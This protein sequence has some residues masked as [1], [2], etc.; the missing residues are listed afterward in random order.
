MSVRVLV[1]GASGFVGAHLMRQL[2]QQGLEAVGM[3]RM[4]SQS[5]GTR[6][7]V[8]DLADAASLTGALRHVQ[9]THVFHLAGVLADAPGGYAAQYQT[10]VLGTIRLFEAIVA[11]GISPWILVA[12][13]AA[14]YGATRPEDNPLREDRPLRPVTHY[15]ASKAAQE[16]AAI[17]YAF[18]HR[19][20]V[21][22]ARTFNL[23]GPGQPGGLLACDLA[24]QIVEA[25][26]RGTPA[27][28]RVGNLSPRRDYVDVRDAVRAYVRLAEIGGAE[29]VYNV[30]T[31]RSISVQECLE[32]LAALTQAPLTIEQ[33]P[34]LMRTVDIA[35]QAGCPDRLQRATGWSAEIPLKTSLSDLLHDWRARVGQGVAAS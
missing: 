24:R 20:P 11:A 12:S 8:G 2:E 14:V 10:N 13:S 35:E 16:M 18:S 27:V 28:V 25:E 23:V 29:D 17:P 22:R 33:D 21:V 6:A 34:A 30:C 19:L 32:M 15:G 26:R 1:T 9:P 5:P 7:V 3:V 31:G 4:R